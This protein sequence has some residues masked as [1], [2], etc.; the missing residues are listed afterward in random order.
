MA[1]IVRITIATALYLGGLAH[2]STAQG[3]GAYTPGVH[4]DTLAVVEGQSYDLPPFIMPGSEHVQAGGIAVPDS[5]F[6]F[7]YRFGTLWFIGVPADSVVVTY[8]T[9]PFAFRDSY[10]RRSI[11]TPA[12]DSILIRDISELA[13]VAQGDQPIQTSD[14][15]GDSK[16][17]RHGSISRG[18]IAGNNRNVSLESGL[19]IQ[20]SGEVTEGVNVR[21][22]LTDE[23]TPI[24][25]DG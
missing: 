11:E 2:V 6:R 10:F 18:I 21:A 16:L 4:S 12:S 9:Y 13:F 7:D 22:V 24:Q 19:R 8:R 14:I 5:L 25:P 23:N 17:E 20:L 1:R 15:F 3:V